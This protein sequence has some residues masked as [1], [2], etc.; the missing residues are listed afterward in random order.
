MKEGKASSQPGELLVL[1]EKASTIDKV[2]F[3]SY[4]TFFW[5]FELLKRGVK[6]TITADDL[7]GLINHLKSEVMLKRLL[8]AVQ[9]E[10]EK[11]AASK[12][13][14]KPYKRGMLL[15]RALVRC[16]RYSQLTAIILVLIS[17]GLHIMEAVCLGWLLQSLGPPSTSGGGVPGALGGW[18][19][20]ALLV[21][22]D[23][24]AKF[25]THH[26]FFRAWTLG[27]QLRASCTAAIYDKI[28]RLRIGAISNLTAGKIVNMATTDVE[29]FLMSG[30]F[31]VYL[32]EAPLESL[33]VLIVGVK[34]V[35]YSF[36]V[37]MA[38]LLLLIPLQGEFS[39]RFAK[40]R[41]KVAKLT[42]ERVKLT[43]QVITGAR[44]VKMSAWEPALLR[45]IAG[46]RAKEVSVLRQANFLRAA[47][48]GLFFAQPTVL[49][50]IC[51]AVQSAVR[52]EPLT[53]RAVFVVLSL[54]NLV[55][56]ALGKFLTLAV[57]A[58]S[59]GWISLGR[60][61]E[62]LLME[63]QHDREVAPPSVTLSISTSNAPPPL[64]ANANSNG[65][66][67]GSITLRGGSFHWGGSSSQI[68]TVKKPKRS[69][70]QKFSAMVRGASG[71]SLGSAADLSF[72][73][74]VVSGE[75][76]LDS[77]K[78]T[79]RG[80][81]LEVAPGELV[82][83]VGNVGSSKS[84][85]LMALLKEMVP[86]G[87]EVSLGSAG[88]LAYASQEAWIMNATL[89]ENILFGK[90][91]DTEWYDRVLDACALRFDLAQ[92]PY[93]DLTLIGDRGVNLSGGQ[94]ARIGLARV[95][96]SR[97]DVYLLDDPLSAVDPEVSRRLFE[98]VICGLLK[99]STRILVTHQVHHL[100][101]GTDRIIVLK[102]G[103]MAAIGSYADVA[104]G[105]HLEGLE[106]DQA[107]ALETST[108][109]SAIADI[110]EEE[111]DSEEHSEEHRLALKSDDV[112]VAV[113]SNGDAVSSEMVLASGVTN[114]TA[115][116]GARQSRVSSSIIDPPM[117]GV[118]TEQ[119]TV[120]EQEVGQVKFGTYYAYMQAACGIPRAIILACLMM[121]GQGMV[122][123]VSLWLAHWTRS[124]DQFANYW[125]YG[126]LG[127]SLG[128][129]AVSL[130][131]AMAVFTALVR[132]SHRLHDAMLLRVLYA[133]MAFFDTRP[134]G[135]IL[136]RFAGDVGISD[137]TLPQT[138]Y[139]FI[140]CTLMC[141]GS[142]ALVCAVNPFV[143]LALIPAGL[144]F[145]YLLVLYLTTSREIKRLEA[146]ARSP[147]YSCLSETLDG[148]VTVRA[149]GAQERFLKRFLGLLD[150]NIEAYFAYLFTGRW[151]GFWM[152]MVVWLLLAAAA[153]FSVAVSKTNVMDIQPGLLGAALTYVIQLGGLFQWAV[154]QSAEVENQIISVERII[155]YSKVDQEA[156]RESKQPPPGDWPYEGTIVMTNVWASYAPTAP[157][158]LK[159]LN[160]TIAGGDKVGIVGRTGA[161]KSSLISVLFR[162][163]EY[164]R[165]QGSVEIDG[166]KT[167][168]IGLHELRSRLSV[169][170]QSPFLFSGS[171][172][173]NLDP[174][175]K[176]S[177][178]EVWNALECVQ[179]KIFV[180]ELPGG[181]SALIS[182]SGGNLSV[183]QRQLL[184]LA[185]AI[186]QR[187]RVLV[188]DE[189]TANVD[190]G[191]DAMIQSAVRTQFAS[192]TV[193]MI[194]HRLR[195]IIDCQKVIVLD[196][197]KVV[198]QGHPYTLLTAPVDNKRTQRRGFKAM[199]AETG[200]DE[201]KELARL[202]KEAYR[203]EEQQGM[204]STLMGPQ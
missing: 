5:V 174:F 37:A 69:S 32:W 191:T 199:V 128:T 95:V 163:T 53:P 27:M 158:V 107:E 201:S 137:D 15:L 26:F 59:E 8:E 149:F 173:L 9:L 93:S 167:Y 46:V 187:S 28:L 120:E 144:L 162:L 94:K 6:R 141:I 34:E 154:R 99:G 194:A 176:Y 90:D 142:V 188:M 140:S 70:S 81:D 202:A 104:A 136:N 16:F 60:L 80:I 21:G 43:S 72:K 12:A 66:K 179:M 129:L 114:G 29:R 4:L 13:K 42:D 190:V 182:E 118:V 24:V 22:I 175:N 49:A 147:V 203:Q 164:D 150:C 30:I 103:T 25:S 101:E 41:S 113:V 2:P 189:A 82:G 170:P 74:A 67:P 91:M 39:R 160:L 18:G 169:I 64:L 152:D 54:L 183:G 151:L 20:A 1:K 197:G 153:F 47:N 172:R 57:Q 186:L 58:C 68:L 7:P 85:L 117:R 19:C 52:G 88:T 145:N 131:R 100:K 79:L 55:Q 122:I 125:V 40:L 115:G 184:C 123:A 84:S 165:D 33:A 138:L 44:L 87:G 38:L 111:E 119:A 62:F 45:E 130:L 73:G 168:D 65:L 36:V 177:D 51:F 75:G 31:W 127:L 48:E 98:D 83:I 110:E 204:S 11:A 159:G 156:D 35:G 200:P 56:M 63:E 134:A 102:N 196:A 97:A 155:S 185:R 105:G 92:L 121:L 17:S 106:Q 195:T 71:K 135:R 108:N 61:E 14:G 77:P 86:A 146:A 23:L 180:Q 10:K 148:L 133:P 3:W 192:C 112:S 50:L 198:E 157:P 178:L 126:L 89:R 96:Y 124:T 76:A 139:D 166:I 78:V 143:L 181:L 171:V 116:G 161:G 109:A 132:A 193:V